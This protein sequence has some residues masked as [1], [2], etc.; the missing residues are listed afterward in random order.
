MASNTSTSNLPKESAFQENPKTL[1][2][3]SNVSSEDDIVK[4]TLGISSTS[5]KTTLK[6]SSEPSF[7]KSTVFQIF[8]KPFIDFLYQFHLELT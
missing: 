4:E 6:R 5:E 3:K 7:G 8:C 2:N 1:N